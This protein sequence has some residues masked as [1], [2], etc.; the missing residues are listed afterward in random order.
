MDKSCCTLMLQ[1]FS[2]ALHLS[3]SMLYDDLDHL[4]SWKIWCCTLEVPFFPLSQASSGYTANKYELQGK[5]GSKLLEVLGGKPLTECLCGC[6]EYHQHKIVCLYAGALNPA[7]VCQN[8]FCLAFAA[9]LWGNAS[10]PP[11][12]LLLQGCKSVVPHLL[13][14]TINSVAHQW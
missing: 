4:I 2:L 11:R 12:F 14:S 10:K 13:C 8:F 7:S 6:L 5:A 3:A 1:D 9:G